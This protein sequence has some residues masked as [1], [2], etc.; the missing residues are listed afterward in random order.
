MEGQTQ[1]TRTRKFLLKRK[2]NQN[3]EFLISEIMEEIQNIQNVQM[4]TFA[5]NVM[6]IDQRH[7]TDFMKSNIM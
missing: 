2:K 1:I 6:G 3:G 5:L 4:I 7:K